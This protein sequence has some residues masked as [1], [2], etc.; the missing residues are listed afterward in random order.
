M[1]QLNMRPVQEALVLRGLHRVRVQ[2][3]YRLSDLVGLLGVDKSNVSRMLNGHR[4]PWT[5]SRMAAA[6]GITVPQLLTPCLRCGYRPPAGYTCNDCGS[7]DSILDETGLGEE[8][9]GL[10]VR[11]LIRDA[12]GD[13]VLL[14]DRAELI[15]HLHE[16]PDHADH[17]KPGHDFV[18]IGTE[19]IRQQHVRLHS[20]H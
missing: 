19:A 13:H 17:Y 10:V 7:R 4:N 8:Q 6:L 18:L 5:A 3:G 15:R 2:N 1:G 12:G 9:L 16:H 14:S 11:I 20:S